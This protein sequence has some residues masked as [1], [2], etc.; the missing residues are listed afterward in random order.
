[1]PDKQMAQ[2]GKGSRLK[3]Q[4]KKTKKGIKS[5]AVFPPKKKKKAQQ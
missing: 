4:N 2:T 1:M 3:T 5:K